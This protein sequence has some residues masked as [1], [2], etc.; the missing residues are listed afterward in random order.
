MRGGDRCGRPDGQ[1]ASGRGPRA[2]KGGRAQLSEQAGAARR[3]LC[4]WT[5]IRGQ[6]FKILTTHTHTRT[7]VTMGGDGCVNETYCGK[8]LRYVV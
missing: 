3:A 4:I 6:I 7:V 1:I 8:D 5:L 2:G